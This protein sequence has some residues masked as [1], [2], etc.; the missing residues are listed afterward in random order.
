MITTLRKLGCTES[1]TPV[2]VKSLEDYDG[3]NFSFLDEQI[4]IVEVFPVEKGYNWS[5]LDTYRIIALTSSGV[6]CI[7]YRIY[8]SCTEGRL[9]FQ[10]LK[11][12]IKTTKE[13]K[14]LDAV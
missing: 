13:E 2:I 14:C 10:S 9:E 6:I 7:C 1:Y 4:T 11:K 12:S 8:G 3:P 5:S